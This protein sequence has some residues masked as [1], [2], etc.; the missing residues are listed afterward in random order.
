MVTTLSAWAEF[1]AHLAMI[2]IWVPSLT[3]GATKVP[4]LEID[5]ADAAQVTAV[6]LVPCT[7]AVKCSCIPGLR[8]A[9]R[10]ETAT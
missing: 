9:L 7:V 8:T 6:L 3:T 4:S 10:G 1:V 5:P 2:V